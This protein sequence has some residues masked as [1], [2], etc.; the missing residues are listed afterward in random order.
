MAQV[1]YTVKKGDTLYAIAKNYNT[2]VSALAKLN[3]ISNANLI[4]VGQVLV[5]SGDAPSGSSSTK[6]STSNKAVV[7]RFGLIANSDRNMYAGWTWS[8]ANTDHFEYVW[9]YSWGVGIAAEERG[10]TSSATAMYSTFTAPDYATHVTFQVK[11]ISKTYKTGSGD[12]EKEVHYWTAGWSTK[13]TYWFSENPPKAPGQPSVKIEDYTLTAT[14]DNLQDLNADSIHFQVIQDNGRLFAEDTVPIVTYHASYT[15]NIE[16]GHEYK[17]RARSVRDGKYSDWSDNSDNQ[18]TKPAASSGINVCRATSS[19]SVYLEWDG[20][21]NAESYDIEYANK[22]EYFESNKST[23][24]SG[25]KS[26]QYTLTGLE[27]GQRYF[28]RVRAVNSAGESPWSEAKSVVIG[29]KPSPPTTWSSTTTVVI[30]ESLYLYWVHNS[31]DGSKQVKAELELDINGEVTTKTIDNPTADDEEA[32]D[33]TSMYEFVTSGYTEGMKLKWR[34]KT[35]GITGEYSDWSIQRVV[36]IYAPPTLSMNLLNVNGETFEELTCFPFAVDTIAGPNTQAPIGYHLSIT[37]NESYETVDHLGNRVTINKDGQVYSR[38]F[39]ISENL[40]VTLRPNDV[41][42]ENN[43]SYTVHCIVTMNSGLTGEAKSTFTVAWTDEIYE[44]NAEIGINKNTYSAVIRPYCEAPGGAL[45]EDVTLSVYRRMYDGSYVE[46]ATSLIN[47]QAT[48][49]VDPHPALDLARYRIVA[50]SLTTGSISYTD[51]A[52]PTGGNAIII[53]WDEEWSDF[54][55]VDTGEATERDW[56]GSMVKLPYNI[57]LS[58]SNSIDVSHVEYIGRKHPVGYYGTQLGETMSY[59][60]DIPKYDKETLY[61]LRRLAAWTGDA[62]VRDPSG[63]G[64]WATVSVS[65]NIDHCE[66]TIPVSLEITIVEG[67]V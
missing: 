40:F 36:D 26:T 65:Y 25:I 27:T 66:V 35:C 55:L 28:F 30:G 37:A 31:E 41:D 56:V 22:M 1:T 21:A 4:Y 61:A 14:L 7:D 53:Q 11:P 63:S 19:T 29:K 2:T 18:Q 9:Y 45:I 51:V 5:I 16:P 54:E 57:D 46:V 23:T 58:M 42:L 12:N 10:E 44:P 48:F 52:Q 50:V 33:K 43:I 24:Q 17:V 8:K 20:V 6:S 32:E 47:T 64:G 3:N 62:Y 34:V 67:G 59:S 39:D 13:R 38:Y 15:V 49:V 60:V